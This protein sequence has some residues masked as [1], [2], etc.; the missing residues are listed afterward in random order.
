M[1]STQGFTSAETDTHHYLKTA[2]NAPN[3]RTVVFTAIRDGNN[4][5]IDFEFSLVSRASRD[6]FNGEDITGKRFKELRPDQEDQL[7]AM[8]KVMET[9]EPYNWERI[10]TDVNGV[11]QWLSVSDAKMENCLVR[12]W[13]NITLRKQDEIKMNTIITQ[14]AEEKYLSLFQSIDQGFCI[15]DVLFD[16]KGHPYDYIFIDYNTAFEKQTGLRDARGLSIKSINPHQEQHWFDLYGSIVKNRKPLYFEQEAILINGWYEVSA[17]PLSMDETDN[18]VA[19]IFNDITARK[20]AELE[21][22]AFN[23]RLEAE[24]KE[25]TASLNRINNLLEEKNIE[26]ERSN[27]ELES[28][29]YVASH[30]L[31]EPLRKIQTFLSMISRRGDDPATVHAYMEKISSSAERMSNLIQDVLAYSRLSVDNKFVNVDLNKI[32]ENILSDYEL[33]ISEKQAVINKDNLPVIKAIPQQMHQLFSNLISNSLKYNDGKPV[34]NI[35]SKLLNGNP[36]M[37]EITLSDNGIGFDQQYSD[38][39]FTLFKRLHGKSEYSGTG[40]G[41]SICK[42]IV[43]QHNGT[44]T[45]KSNIGNGALF[46]IQL[47][48]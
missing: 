22:N 11:P 34:I 47:P 28:F 29:N 8:I 1:N 37:A 48:A 14:R 9:G 35:S 46:T 30:D 15:I 16:D 32:V 21:L 44:I 45:A 18:K 33:V 10:I 39:I 3:N 6:F 13:D 31:Q 12:V 2:F 25:R 40:I 26:L 42:K 23:S 7:A 17:F 27:K 19:V 38:Q 43:E 20:K 41:L 5:V 4:N 36:N 24:V